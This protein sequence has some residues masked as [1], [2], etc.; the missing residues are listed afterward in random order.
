ML[1]H[2]TIVQL[3]TT[4]AMLLRLADQLGLD[5][6]MEGSL[7]ATEAADAVMALLDMHVSRDRAA[8]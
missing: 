2:D 3:D 5:A 1:N 8:A 7:A 4:A 6:D